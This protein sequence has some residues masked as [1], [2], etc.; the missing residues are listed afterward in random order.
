M[1]GTRTPY[2]FSF[3]GGGTDLPE[4]FNE[5][6]GIVVSV[7]ITKYI[8]FFLHPYYDE[9]KN[10][11]KYSK[12]ELVERSTDVAHPLVRCALKRFD[13][14]GL[15][16]NS[17]ADIPAGTGLGSSSSFI[18]GLLHALYTQSG[19]FV[20]KEQLASEASHIEIVELNEPIGKQDQY[21][22]AYGGLNRIT[23]FPGGLV[24][25]EPIPLSADAIDRF[26]KHIMVFYS[27]QSRDARTV[28]QD[29][30][31]YLTTMSAKRVF[32]RSMRDLTGPF[33]NSLMSGDFS[34]SGEIL[35]EGWQKKKELS[36]RISNDAIDEY[37]DTAMA[38]G[39]W[40]GKLLGAGGGGFL[41]FIVDLDKRELLRKAMAPLKELDFNFDFFGSSIIFVDGS[42]G[43]S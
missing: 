20:G 37:Y 39:A 23:F 43:R 12:T 18:V 41:L 19:R 6:P 30:I 21:A 17:I 2:R 40:G 35:H 26:R 25:M 42:C 7:T 11:I 14:P 33:I 24:K 16:I 15:D 31:K 27:G 8:Y 32:L 28:L 9:T 1:I 4:F 36:S 29:Q 3:V 22:A 34:T 5:E 13:L 10:L 38:S